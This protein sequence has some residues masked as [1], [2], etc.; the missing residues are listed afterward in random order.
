MEID[1]VIQTI[2]DLTNKTVE[3]GCTEAEATSAMNKVDKLLRVYNITIDKVFLDK[4][5]CIQ[6]D[7]KVEGKQKP[8]I[9][10]CIMNIANFCDCRIWMSQYRQVTYHFFGMET[11]ISMVVYL[12]HLLVAAIDTETKKFKQS[13]MY[14]NRT[15]H[16]RGLVSSF[17]KGM[18]NRLSQRLSDI[19][20]E[21][22]Q[23]ERKAQPVNVGHKSC[24]L[25]VLKN[26]KV[27]DEYRKL[28]LR[29]RTVASTQRVSSR[30]A[31]SSGD[32]AGNRVNIN[33][34]IAGTVSGYL[35]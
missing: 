24:S 32:E 31:Y 1:L 28:G 3:R 33:R 18:T 35:T 17:Q 9:G 14:L 5:K 13:E 34:P 19:T 7:L 2:K 30:S 4:N 26:N 15:R 29:L 12:Y 23:Q 20:F 16:G 6:H 25:V 21:R 22:K 27:D 10:S 11:D 8:P